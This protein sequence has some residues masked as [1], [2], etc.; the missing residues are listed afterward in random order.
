MGPRSPFSSAHS[1]QIVTP[2]SLSE[3]TFVSP[4]K[5]QRSS[6]MIDLRWSF[7]VVSNGK[8]SRKSKRAC[9]PKTERVPVPV[10]SPRGAPFS[11]TSRRRSWY[12]RIVILNKQELATSPSSLRQRRFAFFQ[13]TWLRLAKN[14]PDSGENERAPEERPETEALAAEQPTEE[15]RARR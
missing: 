15:H 1:S 7:F 12:S 9:A 2:F 4:R 13:F 6:W 10:R 14:H 8:R 5:N 11:K 3:R